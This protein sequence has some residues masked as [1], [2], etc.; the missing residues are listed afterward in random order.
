MRSLR[1]SPWFTVTAV[2]TLATGIAASVAMFSVYCR[3]VLNPVSVPDPPSVVSIARVNTDGSLVPTTLSWPRVQAAQRGATSFSAL[4][5]YVNDT[6]SLSATGGPPQELRALRVSAGFLEAIRAVPARGRLFTAA[7]DL[8][9][10]PAVCLLSYQTWQAFFAG[11]EVIGTTIRLSGRSTE[12]VGILPPHLSPPWAD[13]QIL[14]PRVFEDSQTT[15][16]AVTAG[17]SYLSAV[18]RLAPGRTAAQATDELHGLS[19]DY[20]TRFAGRSDTLSEIALTPIVD[21]VVGNRRTT[22]TLLLGV[23]VIV[24]LVACANASA[25]FLSRL[26]SRQRDTAVRQALGATRA[27]IVRGMLAESLTLAVLA[28]SAGLLLG[29]FTLTLIQKMLAAELPPGVDLRLD[30]VSLLVA[31]AATICAALLVGVL[32]ALQVTRPSAAPAVTTF[33][34]RMSGSAGTQRFRRV[35]VVCEV[36]LSTFLLV[37]AALFLTSLA[38]VA[39]SAIGFDPTGVA[40]GAITLPPAAY[41]T[42]D[43]Q[44]AFFVDVLERLKPNPQFEGVAIAFGLPFADDNWVSPYVISGQPIPPP[45]E[46][47]RAGLRIVTE[48]YFPVMRMRLVAGR[49]FS[50]ADRA[51]SHPVCVINESLA[52][53]QFGTRS[54]LGAV[55]LRGRDADQP[56]EIVGVAGDVKTNG[57]ANPAPDELFLPFRQVPRQNAAIVVR[58]ASRPDAAAPVM[59]RAVSAIDPDL[60]VSRFATMDQQLASTLGPERILAGLTSA[61]AALT[62]L[63]AAIGLYAVLAHIVTSRTVEIGIRMAIGADR[64]SILRLIVSGAMRLVGLGIACGLIAALAASWIV[65]SQLH[66]VSPRAPLVYLLVAVLFAAVGA[67]AAIL[68][69]RR[70]SR[71]DP[72]VSLSAS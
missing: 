5:A 19:R 68:P 37:G 40:A 25:L 20:A 62:L 23:V 59:Q 42:G 38:R 26:V 44:A 17:A 13:R 39:R 53:R 29:G 47:R 24:L 31:C 67:A 36:A 65:G 60:P 28:G 46:R 56:F 41:P 43:R 72:L 64:R 2:L 12:V 50:A 48:D 71:V 16:A 3:V 70:A 33:A 58:M 14:V 10:G 34:R 30:G 21:T 32:P 54:A 35:L 51:G 1:H 45:A 57:P 27:T 22:L 7:D 49:F 11:A 69:A 6:V 8:P 52:R 9:N 63:L 61:F 18:G 15:V 66:D 4:G 55:V